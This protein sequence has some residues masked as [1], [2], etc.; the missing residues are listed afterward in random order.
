MKL[1]SPTVLRKRLAITE[2]NL[3][4]V[5]NHLAEQRDLERALVRKAC[6]LTRQ[7]REAEVRR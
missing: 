1:T 3:S 7:L 4:H 6:R 2:R 5:R